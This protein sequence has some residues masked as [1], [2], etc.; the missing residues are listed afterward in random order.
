MATF[1]KRVGEVEYFKIGE[2]RA[3]G[4]IPY[5]ISNNEV[6]LLV[7]IEMRGNNLSHNIIGG[8]IDKYDNLISET[9]VR[10]FNEETGYLIFDKINRMR[11]N[12][13]K[14]TILLEKPKY[15]CSLLKV[16]GDEW[17]NLPNLYNKM[18]KNEKNYLDRESHC[19]KWI[20]LFNFNE[21]STYLLSLG[22]SKLKSYFWKYS[23][24]ENNLFVD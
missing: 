19:L 22:L 7:N 4:I 3:A 21:E 9:M 1:V 6:K 10:E 18:Y 20:N 17:Q 14:E 11:D 13:M 8:K 16:E 15:L 5:L 12:I 23:I 24:D 2:L